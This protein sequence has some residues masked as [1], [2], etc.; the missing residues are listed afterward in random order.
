MLDPGDFRNQALKPLISTWDATSVM[1]GLVWIWVLTKWWSKCVA[2]ASFRSVQSG[3]G[4][5]ELGGYLEDGEPPRSPR[6]A[7]GE[8]GSAPHFF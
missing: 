2:Y 3:G 7:R 4:G 6:M 5:S 8:D 1:P